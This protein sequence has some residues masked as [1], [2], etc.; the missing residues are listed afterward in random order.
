V[1]T[2]SS[3][4]TAQRC[5]RRAQ[6]VVSRA[7]AVARSAAAVKDSTRRIL[8]AGKSERAP[9]FDAFR[10]G[11]RD[12]GYI[13]G[14]NIILEFRL[15]GGN[16]PSG[17]ELA[18]ELAALPVDVIVTE[19]LVDAAVAASCYIPI[20]APAVMDPVQRGFASSLARPGRNFTSMTTGLIGARPGCCSPAR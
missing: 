13:E 2:R 15:A 5:H 7:R 10:A 19:G 14:R 8:T 11:L 20:V 4:E 12:L 9:K 3:S 17:P 6:R 16:L 1:S 18:T